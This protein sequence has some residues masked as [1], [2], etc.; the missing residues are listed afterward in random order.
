MFI[1]WE[2]SDDMLDAYCPFVE[3][4]VRIVR[5]FD[6]RQL[7]TGVF[8]DARNPQKIQDWQ[9]WKKLMDF[10]YTYLFPLQKDAA[11]LGVKGD[12]AGGFKDIDLLARN[13]RRMWGDV[14]QEQAL[15]AHMQGVLAEAV[16]LKPWTEHL[17]PT[18]DQERLMTYRAL[19]SGVKGITYLSER[20]GR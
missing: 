7:L 5:R 4:A 8:M 14:F 17:I 18:A 2:F 9:K 11:T 6:G 12:I 1:G 3:Q 13:T 15:Q 16:G 10:P 20:A 19:L